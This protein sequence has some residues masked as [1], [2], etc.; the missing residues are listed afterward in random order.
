MKKITIFTLLAAMLLS[1]TV[2]L[3][4]CGFDLG[5]LLGGDESDS[6]GVHDSDGSESG[7][8]G[9]VSS[10]DGYTPL[11]ENGKAKYA[12]CYQTMNIIGDVTA[13]DY[14]VAANSL[15]STL[16]SK[17]NGAG[18]A[19]TSDKNVGGKGMPIISVGRYDGITDKLYDG[20]RNKDFRIGTKDGNIGFACYDSGLLKVAASQFNMGVKL[21]DG[22]LYVK[23]DVLKMEVI[24]QRYH[25]SVMTLD[26]REIFDHVISYATGEEKEEA[27]LIRDLI[28]KYGGYV[29][30]VEMNSSSDKTIQ[31]KKDDSIDGFSIKPVG[32]SLMLTYSSEF[33]WEVLLNHMTEKFEEHPYKT[34]LE[35]N[36]I[37][38]VLSESNGKRII[39]FNVLNVWTNGQD[40]STRD[41]GTAAMVLEYMPDFIC[42][43]EFDIGYRNAANGFISQVSHIY[44]E[45]AVEG[46]D[47]NYVWNP[48]FYDKTKYT[49]VE[50]GY[51]YFPEAIMPENA[52][53]Y[54]G[55][56]S[57]YYGGTPDN[58]ARFRSLVWAVLEDSNGNKYLIGNTHLSYTD[59]E[60]HQP[61]EALV[62]ETTI[63]GV[64]NKYSGCV[65]LVAGD[66]N[67]IIS[68]TK[69]GCGYLLG[70]GFYDT[71]SNADYKNDYQTTHDKGT[72]AKPN[73]DYAIDH[74]LT[75]NNELNVDSYFVLTQ[76][77]V[78]GLSD[79]LPTLVQFN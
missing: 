65:T 75:L 52:S 19:V 2:T 28:V 15:A 79:H 50:C 21:V 45:V 14:A 17:L 77:S 18:F 39:S 32:S 29:L 56:S 68:D 34:P 1:L 71:Y 49:V 76:E 70:N 13:S 27:I 12:I 11:T 35:L 4:G 33:Q 31:I 62:I 54:T 10:V 51:V 57:N 59:S 73:Y 42:L 67:S 16:N 66:Y 8:S 63:K 20:L 53:G 69:K 47:P 23:D 74:I 40:P 78:L 37:E 61:Q 26:G 72:A 43:Q 41:D 9:A 3:G 5:A 6:Q 55:E 25:M 30:P 22:E 46:V 38:S 58:K 48:I 44:S 36:T 24:E 7:S 64:A 60:I